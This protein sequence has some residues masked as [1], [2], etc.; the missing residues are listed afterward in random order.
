M[1]KKTNLLVAS[2]VFMISSSASWALS[3]D[4]AAMRTCVYGAKHDPMYAD[5]S[6]GIL[7]SCMIFEWKKDFNANPSRY[8]Y[9]GSDRGLFS[10]KEE[11]EKAAASRVLAAIK[12]HIEYCA[13]LQR[14]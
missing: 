10:Q 11:E 1:T 12:G 5:L 4:Q 6:V 14:N 9:D 3:S 13:I 8:Q 2:A 7:C